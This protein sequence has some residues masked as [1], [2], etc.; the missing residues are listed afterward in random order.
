MVG[1]ARLISRRSLEFDRHVQ[2]LCGQPEWL[3]V[4]VADRSAGIEADIE[5]GGGAMCRPSLRDVECTDKLVSNE[6]LLLI[7]SAPEMTV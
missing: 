4:V 3:D 1:R 6:L 2:V 7:G 5:A